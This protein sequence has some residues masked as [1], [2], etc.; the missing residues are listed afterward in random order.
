[1]RSNLILPSWLQYLDEYVD[2]YKLAG[3]GSSYNKISNILNAYIG[4][5]SMN[6]DKYA[7]MGR[8]NPLS[9]LADMNIFISE[10]DIPDK[11]RY[12]ECKECEKTCFQCKDAL[13]KLIK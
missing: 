1:M 4:Q 5:K 2:V 12:C 7:S 13:T 10:S 8:S 9:R 3:R 6:I 11:V